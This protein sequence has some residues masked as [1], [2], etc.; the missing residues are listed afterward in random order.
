MWT[1]SVRV[2]LTIAMLSCQAMAVEPLQIQHLWE[3]DPKLDIRW[4]FPSATMVPKIDISGLESALAL[5]RLHSA[6]WA[7]HAAEH[8]LPPQ[9][10]SFELLFKQLRSGESNPQVR[11]AIV[12]AASSV[13]T[14]EEIAR[15]WALVRDDPVNSL[16]VEQALVRLRHPAALALW[17]E[18]L[19]SDDFAFH[20]WL[21]ACEGL[22]V[23]GNE[24]DAGMF[25]KL[26]LK[27]KLP[28]PLRV[29]ASRSL[30][31]LA[32]GAQSTLAEK[33]LKSNTEERYLVAANMLVNQPAEDAAPI[34]ERI[35][36][37]G[38]TAAQG[39]A[40]AGLCK[41]SR[42]RARVLAET[43]V[44]HSEN[45][46]R[47]TALKL[48][49]TFD[50]IA[51]MDV[52]VTCFADAHPTVRE[53]VRHHLLAKSTINPE[54]RSR[55]DEIVTF[56]LAADRWQANEQAIRLSAELGDPSRCETLVKMLVHPIPE[57]HVPA[58]WA[59]RVLADSPETYEKMFEHVQ[60]W[61][62]RIEN[63]ATAGQVTSDD[64]HRVA[65]LMEALGDR[66]YEPVEEWLRKYVPKNGYKMGY[67]TR[68]GAVW[69][70]GKYWKD[71]DNAAL[72]KQLAERAADKNGMFPEVEGV[73][74]T[75]TLAIGWIADPR[76]RAALVENNEPV[77]YPI[78]LATAWALERID[79]KA[80]P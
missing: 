67:V 3:I 74:F 41:V 33:I 24:S 21:I 42:D 22:A 31:T 66:H 23:S 15:L 58:A 19:G 18:R 45:T 73:R 20:N 49:Q 76:S 4:I 6:Q 39:A 12:S 65:H 52:Q 64:Q 14:S 1:L 69:A 62:E 30:G 53:L 2:W 16:T 72:I 28:S 25:E 71:G 56:Q 75:A 68:I 29:A 7:Q 77:P 54:L 40:Y 37:N 47:V 27:D 17:R 60:L 35:I 61:T 80:K 78:G 46:V 36:A 44:K 32:R 48:L 9:K 50:D 13:A 26:L 70:I 51:S 63:P 57:V 55:V 10:N 79:N 34:L 5:D 59:L 43:M 38:P 11:R 8:N